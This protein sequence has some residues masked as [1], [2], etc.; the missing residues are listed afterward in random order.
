M[1]DDLES[2]TGKYLAMAHL[3][4]EADQ[5]LMGRALM[6]LCDALAAP[7]ATVTD[8]AAPVRVSGQE[9]P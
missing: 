7:P 2:F 5:A 1:T 8:G 9:V 6:G 3:D 4:G